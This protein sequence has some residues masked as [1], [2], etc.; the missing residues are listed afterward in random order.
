ML[1]AILGIGVVGLVFSVI[2]VGQVLLWRW[3]ARHKKARE[4]LGVMFGIVF[5][6]GGKDGKKKD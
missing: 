4:L 2:Q 3:F 6:P 5:K 1:G